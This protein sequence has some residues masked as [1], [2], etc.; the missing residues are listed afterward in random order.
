M[1]EQPTPGQQCA[2][3]LSP[4]DFRSVPRELVLFRATAWTFACPSWNAR[5]TPAA[6]ALS[7]LALLVPRLS[8]LALRR[9]SPLPRDVDQLPILRAPLPSIVDPRAV[10]LADAA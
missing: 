2:E 6:S 9:P 5:R 8:N 3:P 7:P 4:S 1:L 10:P